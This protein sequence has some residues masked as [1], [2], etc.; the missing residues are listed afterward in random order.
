MSNNFKTARVVRHKPQ[1]MFDLVADVERYPDFVPLCE[2]LRV[3][4]RVRAEAVET[5]VAD[6]SVGYRLYHETF[7]SRVELNHDELTI[8]ASYVDG[9]FKHMDNLW[10]FTPHPNGCTVHFAIDYEFR[11]RSLELV[12]GSLFDRAFRKF[13]SA[14]EAR[15]D[16]VYGRRRRFARIAPS[17]QPAPST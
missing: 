16:Q 12:V 10:R 3:T 4:R 13:S 11:S 9:P 15:A 2:R 17:A 6:M 14:F 5:V 1:D 7:T 8:R